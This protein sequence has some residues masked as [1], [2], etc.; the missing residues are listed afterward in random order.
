VSLLNLWFGVIGSVLVMIIFEVGEFFSWLIVGLER[1]VWV[2]VMIMFVVL[3]VIRVFVVFMMVFLV[4]I[5][6]LMSM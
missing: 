6:L 4:L 5:M 3:L 1:I 2:V